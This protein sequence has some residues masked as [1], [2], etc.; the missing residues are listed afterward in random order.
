SASAPAALAARGALRGRVG[1]VLDP[2]MSL[3]AS[4]ALKPKRSVTVAF[5]TTVGRSRSAAVELARKYGSLHAARWA[6][7]D[8]EQDSPRRLQ[9]TTVDP[10]LLPT[11]Q[12]LF[13][14]LVFADPAVRAASDIAA[15]RPSKAQLWGRGISG[16]DPIV[17][18]RVHDPEAP[19]LAEILAVQRYLRSCSVTFDLVL[20]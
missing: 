19:M 4:V 6:I 13:S 7:R 18:V 10:V 2:V 1:A 11:I 12:R 15:A 5:V 14:S 17:V 3:M 20:L 9:R 16:D 8:A